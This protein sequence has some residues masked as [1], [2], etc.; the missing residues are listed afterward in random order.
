LTERLEMDYLTTLLGTNI[1]PDMF[2]DDVLFPRVGY[3]GS[4]EG[5]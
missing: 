5:I 2:E 3:V 1:S 4:L